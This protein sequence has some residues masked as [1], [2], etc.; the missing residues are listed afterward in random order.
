MERHA[1]HLSILCALVFAA[2]GSDEGTPNNNGGEPDTAFYESDA[3]PEGPG[4]DDTGP[5]VTEDAGDGSPDA[6]VDMPPTV[7]GVEVSHDREL[8]GVWI[9]T[10]F[11]ISWPS[12]TGLSASA[13][14]AELTAQLDVAKRAGLNTVF[15]QIRAE[16]DAFYPSTIEPWSRFL[17]GTMGGDPGYD[18]LEFAIVEAH[19][20]GLELHAWMNPYRALAGSNT[21]VASSNHIVKARSN[22]VVRYGNVYWMNPGLEAVRTQ[23]LD[24]VRDVITR[25]DIDGLHFDDYFYPYPTADPFPDSATYQAYRDA[26]GTLSLGDFRRNNVNLLVEAVHELVLQ[27]RPDV[28][29]GISPFGIYRPG[30]PEGITGLDQYDAIYADPLRWLEGGWVDYLAPQLYWPTTQTAQAYG[31]LLNWWSGRTMEA[32]KDLFVGNYTSQLGTSGAWTVSELLDQIML[33]RMARDRGALGNIHYHIGPLQQNRSGLVD[34]LLRDYYGVPAAPPP[35]PGAV[36]RP[37][38]PRFAVSGATVT[39]EGSGDIRYFAVYQG[40]ALV[41]LI[42]A[43][44]DPFTLPRGDYHV[45]VIDR[46]DLESLG[47]PVTV[48]EG[49]VPAGSPCT[50]SFGGTYAHGA[51]SAS[52]QCCDGDWALG[53][54]N[55]GG[56][57][58][59]EPTG[60]VGC[61]P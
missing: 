25:Y 47:T 46:H 21:N 50:H 32:G 30:I 59:T 53:L 17:T 52:Y 20:R 14:R 54:N 16:A 23:T 18:P 49:S 38:A 28:R 10:V 29:F 57:V 35:I 27:H 19:K 11:N 37:P 6:E 44:D 39:F 15:F 61:M 31:T 40:D 43:V 26:G 13:Q 33:T 5:V 36:G 51:C 42:P 24:V 7:E 58:C 12:R 2:C 34:A 22:L 9:P 60:M 3:G 8:R 1:R 4:E 45:S 48:E 41:R 56:C 55:C